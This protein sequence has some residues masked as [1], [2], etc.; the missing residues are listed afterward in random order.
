MKIIIDELND[1][2][3]LSLNPL[4]YEIFK[5]KFLSTEKGSVYER[6]YKNYFRNKTVKKTILDMIVDFK[7]SDDFL[8]F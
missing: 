6:I 8:P 4:E 5:A 7:D 1:E 2:A 3:V